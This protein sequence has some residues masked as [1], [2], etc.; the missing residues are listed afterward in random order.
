[1][2]KRV[3][4]SWSSLTITQP[5]LPWLKPK[6][7]GGVMKNDHE[8]HQWQEFFDRQRRGPAHS[9]PDGRMPYLSACSSASDNDVGTSHVLTPAVQTVKWRLWPS[10][11]WA[12]LA[13]L[14]VVF[15]LAAAVFV[16]TLISWAS[17]NWPFLPLQLCR[18]WRASDLPGSLSRRGN[19]ALFLIFLR[20]VKNKI[21]S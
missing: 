14:G 16:A 3:I 21:Q 12:A 9:P 7:H 4:S 8:A 10:A 19:C 6:L 20:T 2:E 18:T 15:A 11:S 13:G 5:W 1:M 17:S